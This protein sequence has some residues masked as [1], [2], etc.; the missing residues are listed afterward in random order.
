MLLLW[1]YF[2]SS[3]LPLSALLLSVLVIH[4]SG[5][6]CSCFLVRMQ[7][8][9]WLAVNCTFNQMTIWG[10]FE[11]F[12]HIS[13]PSIQTFPKDCLTK[14]QKIGLGLGLGLGSIRIYAAAP[15]FHWR[16]VICLSHVC[17]SSRG[18]WFLEICPNWEIQEDYQ[19]DCENLF[20]QDLCINFI[21]IKLLTCSECYKRSFKNLRNPRTSFI[22]IRFLLIISLDNG[23]D[24]AV[25]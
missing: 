2:L 5:L 16:F 17:Y 22:W 19:N 13:F 25:P 3:S 11:P 9:V 24:F 6:L 10:F 7:S 1:S 20:C 8:E 15:E 23:N 12:S 14:K 4:F 18:C 21:F